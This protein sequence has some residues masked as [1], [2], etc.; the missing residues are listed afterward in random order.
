MW[1]DFVT[2][3]LSDDFISMY[4]KIDNNIIY[5]IYFPDFMKPKNYY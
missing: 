1:D 3:K 5:A 4:M 2:M